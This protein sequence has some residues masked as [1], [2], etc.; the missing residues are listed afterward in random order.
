MPTTRPN[1][2][3]FRDAGRMVPAEELLILANRPLRPAISS[4]YQPGIDQAAAG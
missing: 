1:G 4:R 3:D 2:A